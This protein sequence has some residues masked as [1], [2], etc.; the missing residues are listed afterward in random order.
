[1]VPQVFISLSGQDTE[2]AAAVERA[3]PRGLARFYQKTFSKNF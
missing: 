3:L 2:F 1:M